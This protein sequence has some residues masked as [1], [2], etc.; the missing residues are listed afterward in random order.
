MVLDDEELSYQPLHSF[1][2]RSIPLRSVLLCAPRKTTESLR[3]VHEWRS[4][5]GREFFLNLAVIQDRN[6]FLD[7]LG[8]RLEWAGLER[9]P[10]AKHTWRRPGW[11]G[12]A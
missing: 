8:E 2:L 12:E 6:R 9:D 5:E 7:L 11:H 1:T 10:E 4:G 3:L